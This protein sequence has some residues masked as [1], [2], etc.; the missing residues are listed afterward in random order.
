ML[1]LVIFI[2]CSTEP[3]G[4]ITTSLDV[5]ELMDYKITRAKKISIG[6]FNGPYPETIKNKKLSEGLLNNYYKKIQDEILQNRKKDRQIKISFVDTEEIGIT[7]KIIIGLKR[8]FV[9]NNNFIVNYYN[10]V[11]DVKVYV[12]YSDGLVSFKIKYKNKYLFGYQEPKII[13]VSQP[14]DKL[15]KDA[16][17]DWSEVLIPTNDGSFTKY[18]IMKNPVM[19]SDFYKDKYTKVPRAV[20]Q[21]SFSDADDYC[22]KLGGSIASLYVFEYALRNGK[23][24]F[25]SKFGAKKEMLAAFDDANDED[26][27]LKKPGDIVKLKDDKCEKLLDEN[28]KIDC[29]AKSDY[30]NMLVFDFSTYKYSKA[31]IDYQSSE[32]TFRCIK[33]GE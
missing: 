28:E 19:I 6:G 27:M 7:R 25:A 8:F 30:S 20:T 9:K 18:L 11:S 5:D 23:I 32:L 26:L 15:Q 13:Q 22:V 2:G 29:Y 33:K 24:V 21:I 31:D 3:T 4:P 10:D 1:V 12:N 16:M 14:L 17:S